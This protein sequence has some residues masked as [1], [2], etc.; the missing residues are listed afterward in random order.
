MR[1]RQSTVRKINRPGE[2]TSH[3]ARTKYETALVSRLPQVGVGGRMPRPR[4]LSADSTR[5]IAPMSIAASAA[6]ESRADGNGHVDVRGAEPDRGPDPSAIQEAHRL[7]TAQLV[8]AEQI[9][10]ILEGRFRVRVKEMLLLEP[11]ME[12]VVGEQRRRQR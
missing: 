2:T 6:A 4:K 3:H 7:A 12:D 5:M 8:R 1:Y 9:R 10:R 11:V